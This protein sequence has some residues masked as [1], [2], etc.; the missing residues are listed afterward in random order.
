MAV[1]RIWHQS[2]TEIDHIGVYKQSLI[3]RA[4]LIL[5]AD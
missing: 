5:D 3:D 4:R 1:S 2:T